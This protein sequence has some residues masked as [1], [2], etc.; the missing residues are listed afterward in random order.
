MSANPKPALLPLRYSVLK[1]M[2]RSPLHAFYA[3]QH[4]EAGE[5]P[6]M[7]MGRLTHAV[8]LGQPLPLVWPGDRRGKEWLAFRDA[9]EGREIVK[10][11][12]LDIALAMASC[13]EA[14]P[15]AS[16]LLRG[17]RETTVYFDVAGRHCRATP[18]VLG[19]GWI[20]DLKTT[21]DASPVRFPWQALRLGYHGQLAFYKDAVIEAKAGDPRE[22]WIVA[23][24]SKEPY[25]VAT[26]Q[27]TD[28]AE[29]FGRRMWRSWFEQFRV[30]EESNLWEGYGP[31]VLDAPAE[32][33]E[34]VGA[35]GEV[36]EVSE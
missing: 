16:R 15:E 28:A 31:G 24:E 29:D 25:A 20:A 33:V 13:L 22:L 7:K 10:Q 19:D 30:C 3:M 8:A 12:E 6:S 9:N 27:L 2:G 17:V 36:I 18:D 14:H 34:L 4:P 5:T 35:D 21:S 11:D 26:Y 32:G 1:Q 23:I